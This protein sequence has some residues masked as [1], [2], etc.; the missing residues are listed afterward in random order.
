MADMNAADV[1]L[2]AKDSD[3]F[4]NSWLGMIIVLFFLVYGMGGNWGNNGFA[5]AIGYENL[6]TSNEVQRGFD[7]QNSMANQREILAAVNAGTAQGVA[8][9]N[10]TFHD[11]L[12]VFSDKYS[13]LQ[14]DIGGLAV[15]Q[16][17]LMNKQSECCCEQ[18]RAIDGVN[19]NIAMQGNQIV[20]AVREEGA[21][22]RAQAQQDKMDAMAARIQQLENQQ[23][24]GPIMQRLSM[25]PTYPNGYVYSAGQN[26]F[27]NCG[28][29]GCCNI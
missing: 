28:N 15:G 19:Y 21:A 5:N 1:A 16:Q 24:L 13:E 14:R 8:A 7:N 12:G 17:A 25:I 18:L 26:P 20:Q 4:G 9:T 29:G 11:M 22:T 23:N 2:L 6:S 27:C 3:N 10:Q